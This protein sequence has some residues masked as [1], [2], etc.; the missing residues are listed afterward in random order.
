MEICL[1]WP[2]HASYTARTCGGPVGGLAELAVCEG[3]RCEHPWARERTKSKATAVRDA[4]FS[5][6]LEESD[7]R[8]RC[9][10]GA[11]HPAAA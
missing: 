9:L 6:I 7:V 3:A 4:I 2:N 8:L 1:G 10:P 5:P 11:I